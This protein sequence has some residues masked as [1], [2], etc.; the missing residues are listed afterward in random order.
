VLDKSS[1]MQNPPSPE[2]LEKLR[3]NC[4]TP[5]EFVKLLKDVGSCTVESKM[6][7]NAPSQRAEVIQDD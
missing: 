4:C 3:A 1:G 5:E 2:K 6:P 7:T